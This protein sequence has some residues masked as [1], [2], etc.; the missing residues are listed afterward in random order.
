[1]TGRTSDEAS[2]E[3]DESVGMRP[4]HGVYKESGEKPGSVAKASPASTE[5]TPSG[6]VKRSSATPASSSNATGPS[7]HASIERATGTHVQ[8][9]SRPPHAYCQRT[10]SPT[11]PSTTSTSKTG[12]TA[13]PV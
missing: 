7:K 5:T 4:T 11:P 9:V 1:M 3:G 12:S 6:G 13:A 2:E 8:S 10:A